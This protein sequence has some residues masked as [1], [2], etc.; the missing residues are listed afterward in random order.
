MTE[1]FL[2]RHPESKL[3]VQ[4][5]LVSGRSNHIGLTKKGHKEA[6][7]FAETF[8]RAFPKPDVLC[9]SPAVRTT[10]LMEEFT[11]VASWNEGYFIEPALQ[12]MTQ[13][14]ADGKESRLIYTPEVQAQIDE[15]TFDFKLP[16]GESLD[17]VADRMLAWMFKM[18]DNYP[19][20]TILASTHGQA[21]RAAVGRLLGWNHYQTTRDPNF[22]TPNVSLTHVVV[23][24]EGI[25]VSY[26]GQRIINEVK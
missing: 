8:H 21:I 26:V 12:E 24:D 5:H 19:G 9:S 14:L 2:V 18:H 13:G 6:R 17:E 23:D 10:T 7:L 1:I 3:N 15:E 22:Q 4:P 20:R 11:K 16:E 25:D